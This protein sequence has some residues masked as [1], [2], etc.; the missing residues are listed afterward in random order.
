MV[1]LTYDQSI[2]KMFEDKIINNFV[3]KLKN[4]MFSSGLGSQTYTAFIE[5]NISLGTHFLGP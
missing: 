3:C 2:A 1:R 5:Q 4:I